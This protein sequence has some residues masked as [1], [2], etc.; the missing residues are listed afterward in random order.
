MIE[1]FKKHY[2][3]KH[4]LLLV[5]VVVLLFTGLIFWLDNYTRH[6]EQKLV[7]DVIG[8]TEENA[9]T[10]ILGREL[11][12]EVVDSVYRTGALPG[13][14][15]DQDPK[16]NSF[17]KKERKIYLIINAKAAQMTKLPEVID[18][19]LRQAQALLAG[20]DFKVKE[21]VYQPSDYRDLVLEVLYDDKIVN[22]GEEIPTYS[23]LILHV[24]DGG[25]KI[26]TDTIAADT[27]AVIEEE[28]PS[29]DELLSD[30]LLEDEILF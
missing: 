5:I 30:D 4:L 29:E 11:N 17:V 2:I 21:V 18:L 28:L 26:E 10:L 25:L 6:N 8:M 13:A 22:A 14:I 7:P 19:S 12:F 16:A 20:A 9:A 27:T 24:G 1:F 3:L 15:V 23:E